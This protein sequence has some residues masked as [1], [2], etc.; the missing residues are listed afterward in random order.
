MSEIRDGITKRIISNGK[1]GS[2]WYFKKFNRLTI[3]VGPESVSKLL[4]N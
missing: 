3:I 2:S 4:L 1:T